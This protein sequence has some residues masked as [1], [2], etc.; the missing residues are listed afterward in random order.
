MKIALFG[1][2]QMGHA[3]A[4]MIKKLG[5][6]HITTFDIM[7][8]SSSL[9]TDKHI[10]FSAMAINHDGDEFKNR[11][12]F[13]LI[14]SSLPY[15][16]TL[17][18][19]QAAIKSNILYCDLGGSVPTSKK[20]NELA[21]KDKATVFTDLGLAPGWA[22]IMAEEA[23]QEILETPLEVKIR[24]GGIP[25][26][27]APE[28]IDPF[29]YKPTWSVQGLYNEYVDSCE[30]LIDGEIK[31]TPSL[32]ETEYVR[33]TS[34]KLES[35]TME[36]LEAF[37]TSGGISHTLQLMKD[38]GVYNCS[39]K[40]LRYQGHRDLISYFLEQRKFDAKQLGSLFKTDRRF[41]DVVIVDVEAIS[42]NDS[43]R[44]TDIVRVKDGYSAMQRATA[45]GLVAAIFA[46]LED[47]PSINDLKRPLGYQDVPVAVFNSFLSE[48][49]IHE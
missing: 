32:K 37:T 17:P 49:E 29:N 9:E 3:I 8:Q 44:K 7:D 6:H 15:Y 19:A 33:I 20:I 34:S 5:K 22:N 2:G 1:A 14:I 23:Y 10:K 40:T 25:E 21:T 36:Y 35:F 16:V 28:S 24:C 41:N 45:G 31:Q 18:V 46:C 47:N 27:K 12:Q 38:R 4:H 13:D 48:L 42:T 43:Y 26:S 11:E 39:Y 30:M